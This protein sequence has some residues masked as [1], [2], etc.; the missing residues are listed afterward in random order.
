MKE[1]EMAGC[2][3]TSLTR[4]R[5]PCSTDFEGNL[6]FKVTLGEK[7]S[8]MTREGRRFAALSEEMSAAEAIFDVWIWW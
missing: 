3:L 6:T 8:G 2:C 4:T 5:V 7:F 1:I